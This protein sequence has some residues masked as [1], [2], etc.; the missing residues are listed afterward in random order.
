MT[1]AKV[2]NT[3][4]SLR[5]AYLRLCDAPWKDLMTTLAIDS[6]RGC[7]TLLPIKSFVADQ[8][9]SLSPR[10]SESC[11]AISW[12][13][14]SATTERSV[15]TRVERLNQFLQPAHDGDA[16]CK[17]LS[18]TDRASAACEGNSNGFNDKDPRCRGSHTSREQ[19][20]SAAHSSNNRTNPLRPNER[21]NE[22]RRKREL[23]FQTKQATTQRRFAN[24]RL[25]IKL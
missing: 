17:P 13:S 7:R 8:R 25:A 19:R 21:P 22:G 16:H 24:I 20:S 3:F 14:A 5:R 1:S 6:R 23:P 18:Q 12:S 2:L 15:P 10:S 4:V 11:L 9:H